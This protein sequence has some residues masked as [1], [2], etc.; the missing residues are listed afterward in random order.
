MDRRLRRR[1][2]LP[3]RARR[4][5]FVA[6]IALVVLLHAIVTHEV[7][8]ELADFSA[9]NAMPQRIQVAYVRTLEPEAPRAAAPA[10]APK[11]AAATAGRRAVHR[12]A[13]A[14]SAAAPAA[15]DAPAPPGVAEAVS[16]AE[17]ALAAGA[18]ASE[19]AAAAAAAFAAATA[20]SEASAALAAASAAALATASA[21]SAAAALSAAAAPAASAAAAGFVWPSATKVSY[22]VDG[23]Y[24]GHIEGK[25]EVE[26]IRVGD[27][28]QVNVDLFA[29][30]GFAPLFSRRMMSEGTVADSG[31]VPDR[32]NEETQFL[33]ADRRR[34]S[35]LFEPDS[36]ELA[37][38]QKHERMPGVQDTASQFIQFTWLFGS[39]PEALVVG[40]SFQFPL[41][42]PR[43]MKTWTY[44]V[45]G[46]ETLATPFGA[47]PAYHLKPRLGERKP[48]ELTVEM[49][50]AP[51]LRFLP[52][53]IR[54]E[55]EAG[56]YVDLMIAKKP[57]I[58]AS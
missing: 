11:P 4:T 17:A 53:R 51:E 7:A 46:E 54:V 45:V 55:Q 32:Y 36:V 44:D 25:A 57:E 39:K 34:V 31:L 24:R 47:L 19:A 41:A 18:S 37:N 12:V 29:G 42:L 6:L 3:R 52:V 48:G 43:S 58:S 14:A 26:W 27:H 33:T 22:A 28:Y 21:A 2:A 5:A 50:F 1:P 9:A 8:A 49:W 20:A 13:R 40:A 15:A 35:V 30:P 56:T 16:A 23:N 38:G 10:A